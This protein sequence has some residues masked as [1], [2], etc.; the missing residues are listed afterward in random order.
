MG[1]TRSRIRR[2]FQLNCVAVR[3]RDVERQAF[4]LGPEVH[5]SRPV[6]GYV[7]RGKVCRQ[8]RFIKRFDPKAVVVI[9]APIVVVLI[10]WGLVRCCII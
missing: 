7:V 10:S 3:V 1:Q 6:N 8:R 9:T 4:P 5:G 2:A